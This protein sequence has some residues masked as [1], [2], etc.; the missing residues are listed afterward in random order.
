MERYDLDTRLR[1]HLL[2]FESFISISKTSD[3]VQQKK[4]GRKGE[5][6]TK[7]GVFSVGKKKIEGVL[8]EIRKRKD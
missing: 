2:F 4:T 3:V 1:T 5:R 7:R 6:Q 8:W